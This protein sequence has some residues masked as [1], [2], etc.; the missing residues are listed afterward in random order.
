MAA[1]GKSISMEVI[2]TKDRLLYKDGKEMGLPEADIL[3]RCHG[4]MFAE[5]LVDHLEKGLPFPPDKGG[6]ITADQSFEEILKELRDLKTQKDD[7]NKAIKKLNPQIEYIQAIAIAKLQGEGAEKVTTS[8][9]SASLSTKD[10][11]TIKDF[12]AFIH[13]IDTHKAYEMIQKRANDAPIRL[14]WED[15]E[16]GGIPGIDSFSRTTLNFRKK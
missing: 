15:E 14:I 4:F 13:Y 16:S 10:Y 6:E 8:F 9:G 1:K 5:R 2:T 3:A 11:A 12:G 7:L